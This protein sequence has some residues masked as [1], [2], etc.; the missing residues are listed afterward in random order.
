MW[1]LAFRTNRFQMRES[2]FRR[3]CFAAQQQSAD[4]LSG[5]LQVV[6]LASAGDGRERCCSPEEQQRG[7][8]ARELLS[9]FKHGDG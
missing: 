9:L 8:T 3:C 4:R 1:L 6:L 5:L 7:E 2:A